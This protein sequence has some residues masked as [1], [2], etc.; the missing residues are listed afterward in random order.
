M[1]TAT[2]TPAQGHCSQCGKVWTLKKE[3]GVCQWCAH[4]AHCQSQPTKP[5]I[6]K[7]SRRP[8]PKQPANGNGNGYHELTGKWLTYYKVA[9]KYA[10]KGKPQDKEDLLH[11]I[12][13]ALTRTEHSNGHKPFTL[14]TM[15][16]IASRTVFD[17]WRAY[18]KVNNG[19]DCHACSKKQRQQCRKRQVYPNCPRAIKLE[20]LNKPIIDNEGNLT[21]LGELVID[22]KSL[23]LTVWDEDTGIWQM[24]YKPRLVEIAGKLKA[25]IAL[26]KYEHTYLV[27]YRKREQIKLI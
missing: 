8:K 7:S 2:L 26:T 25:G 6:I 24:G 15:H 18:Y 23:D 20:S 3:Q 4:L 13:I 12:M 11:D 17:Y 10:G 9:S 5:R 14:G 19:L 21:E 22:P 1:T 27:R 16:R